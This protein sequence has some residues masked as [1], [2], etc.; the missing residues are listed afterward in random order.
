MSANVFRKSLSVVAESAK[1]SNVTTKNLSLLRTA[2][3]LRQTPI[4]GASCAFSAPSFAQPLQRKSLQ[5]GFGLNGFESRR[6]FATSASIPLS[7]QVDLGLVRFAEPQTINK[8][9][10]K[11]V[12]VLY[13]EQRPLRLQ[14]PKLRAP[15]G[16]QR[17]S[18]MGSESESD[19]PSISVPISFDGYDTDPEIKQFYDLIQAIDDIV[20]KQAIANVKSWFPASVHDAPEV[21]I[22]FNFRP[23][24]RPSKDPKYAPSMKFRVQLVGGEPTLQVYTAPGVASSVDAITPNS[25]LT[26]IVELN[27]VWVVGNQYGTAWRV[28]QT[29]VE[30]AKSGYEPLLSYAIRE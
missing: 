6:G 27:G 29:K 22:R 2:P 4:T 23:T 30:S 9:G 24:A 26:S 8:R 16:I 18:P 5:R 17:N 10:G 11:Y 28:L 25:R 3:A 14:T 13:D 1:F 12:N 20:I 7:D 15:F 21:A 19:K